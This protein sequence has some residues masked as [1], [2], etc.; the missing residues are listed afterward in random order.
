MENFRVKLLRIAKY[1]FDEVVKKNDLGD[2]GGVRFEKI[3]LVKFEDL[4]VA[5]LA[6][7]EKGNISRSSISEF[8]GYN[9]DEEVHARKEEKDLLEELGLDEY[10]PQP[11]DKPA[12]TPNDIK[13]DVEST[14]N[15]PESTKKE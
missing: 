3:N 2:Y 10:N 13:P 7:Y 1:I 14:E 5:L 9:W 12:D 15:E 8:Y 4:S 11:F 6:L